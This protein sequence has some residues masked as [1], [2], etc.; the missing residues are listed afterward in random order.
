MTKQE[1]KDIKKEIKRLQ[2]AMVASPKYYE[3]YAQAIKEELA[4]LEK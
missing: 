2:N 1:V 3:M 4:K